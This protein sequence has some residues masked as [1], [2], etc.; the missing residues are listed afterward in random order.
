MEGKPV[1]LG[2][3]L[4]AALAAGG[5][6]LLDPPVPE[7][8]RVEVTGPPGATV[9][10]VTSTK[11]VHGLTEAGTTRVVVVSAD[12]AIVELPFQSRTRI[13]SD[14]RFFVAAESIDAETSG[15]RMQ[16]FID[17][18]REYDESGTL[19]EASLFRFIYTFN[20][21]MTDQVEVLF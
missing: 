21:R 13:R 8:A 17:T 11:F 18:S 5:C 2:A 6:G 20:Q 3:V 4:L 12:T 16:V 10:L 1:W 15:F 9:R 7:E 14:Q 19:G